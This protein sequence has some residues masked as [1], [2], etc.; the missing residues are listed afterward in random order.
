MTK[1]SAFSVR[2]RRALALISDERELAVVRRQLDR[3]G[4]TI[5]ECGPPGRSPTHERVDVVI[6][7]ADILPVRFDLSGAWAPG[8]P[9]IALVGTETPSRLK[10]MLELD[11]ASFLVKPL[12]SAGLYTALVLA[13]DRAKEWRCRQADRE[14]G[15]ARSGA[16]HRSGRPA[17]GHAPARSCR[18]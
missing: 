18:T 2:G 3:F 1:A 8:A 16:A 13:F 9:I 12:R 4:M 7:D 11:P 17:T 14:A 15:R 6:I 10:C 5:A